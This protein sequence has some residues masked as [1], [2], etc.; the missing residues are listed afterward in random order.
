MCYAI[1][2][3]WLRSRIWAYFIR[4]QI[5]VLLVYALQSLMP[6]DPFQENMFVPL[7]GLPATPSTL[8]YLQLVTRGR[9]NAESLPPYVYVCAQQALGK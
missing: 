4:F 1:M 3:M 6:F 2:V 5:L 8:G 9:D 7:H